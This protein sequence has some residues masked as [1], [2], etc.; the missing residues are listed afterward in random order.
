MENMERLEKKNNNSFCW[1]FQMLLIFSVHI[2][3]YG[4]SFSLKIKP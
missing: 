1:G 2:S 4:V 3:S